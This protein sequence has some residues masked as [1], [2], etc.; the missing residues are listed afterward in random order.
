MKNKILTTLAVS[1]V[2]ITTTLLVPKQ[3]FY[4]GTFANKGDFYYCNDIVFGED[5]VGTGS[6]KDIEGDYYSITDF[7]NSKHTD[8]K[9]TVIGGT[10]TGKYAGS[11]DIN[12]SD[13]SCSRVIVYA[14]GYKEDADKNLYLAINDNEQKIHK[15]GKDDSYEF[16]P[17]TFENIN[18]DILH[19]RNA[20]DMNKGRI[21]ISKIVFRLTN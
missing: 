17:Y 4:S 16:R 13:V 5:V 2:A 8:E 9:A 11:F 7:V 14:C 6:T 18:S 10:T 21:C 3:N 12:L 20:I 15:T 1:L 19:F